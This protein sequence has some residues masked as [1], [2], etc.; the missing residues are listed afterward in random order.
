MESNKFLCSVVL[1]GILLISQTTYAQK[2]NAKEWLRQKKTQRKYF[3]EQAV[4]LQAY[5]EVLKKGYQIA[6]KGLTLIGDVSGEEFAGHSSRLFNLRNSSESIDK[7]RTMSDARNLQRAITSRFSKT[8]SICRDDPNFADT[9]KEYLDRVSANVR[10]LSQ[11]CMDELQDLLYNTEMVLTHDERMGRLNK[12][13][14]E[15]NDQYTFTM[16]FCNSALALRMERA[17][18]KNDIKFANTQL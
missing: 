2:P 7:T 3:A 11:S 12:V 1:T 18:E 8:N 5:L 9:E 16:T 15:M 17:K 4:A 14:S 6:G 10:D 13:K